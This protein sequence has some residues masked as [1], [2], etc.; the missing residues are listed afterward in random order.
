MN[1]RNLEDQIT[2]VKER[3]LCMDE[4][5]RDQVLDR[6]RG[7]PEVNALRLIDNLFAGVE[8]VPKYDI[9]I[10]NKLRVLHGEEVSKLETLVENWKQ[11]LVEKDN[12]FA[13]IRVR[14]E[15]TN[16]FE[17]Y[18]KGPLR[19][20]RP[21]EPRTL[22]IEN[23]F[24]SLLD[25]AGTPIMSEIEAARLITKIM[26]VF[27]GDR[28][29]DVYIVASNRQLLISLLKRRSKESSSLNKQDVTKQE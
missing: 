12:F 20:S 29:P 15:I 3:F 24:S 8:I 13:G 1:T 6:I 17:L 16:P 25:N 23:L 22:L 2:L 4:K 19:K 7:L 26:W 28:K 10:E 14:V 18:D 5:A 27:F 21:K 11:K 9:R